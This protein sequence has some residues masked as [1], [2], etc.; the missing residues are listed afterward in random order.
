MIWSSIFL[1]S[2]LHSQLNFAHILSYVFDFLKTREME[3]AVLVIGG[4]FAGITASIELAN[5]GIN[6]ILVDTKEFFEY[7]PAIL[8]KLVQ[9]TTLDDISIPFSHIAAKNG[10]KFVQGEV[11]LLTHNAANIDVEI[12][13]FSVVI[14]AVGCHYVQPIRT[15]ELTIKGR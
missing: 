15:S 5:S 8:R 2:G 6:T 12:V 9:G 13:Q 14:V 4:G 11:S 1:V 7:T 3:C 10:F